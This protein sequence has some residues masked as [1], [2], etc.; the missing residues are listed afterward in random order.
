MALFP[1]HTKLGKAFQSRPGGT[2]LGSLLKGATS[3][4]PGVG[5]A[6]SSF[7]GNGSATPAPAAPALAALSQPVSYFSAD[8]LPV[9]ASQSTTPMGAASVATTKSTIAVLL[10]EIGLA[11][12]E[13]AKS[14][15]TDK[16]LETEA[17]KK[18]KNQGAMS[19]VTD[20]VFAFLG[21]AVA[22][23]ILIVLALRKR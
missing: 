8:Q 19:F 7:V 12:L 13:G 14:K 21:G 1:K 6:L 23:G 11:G 5:P 10:K 17:G 3:F 9:P 16:F 18:A 20:N 2:P 22:L 15:A 4:I